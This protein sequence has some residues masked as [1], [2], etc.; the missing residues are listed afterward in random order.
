MDIQVPEAPIIEVNR[1]L[2]RLY[3]SAAARSDL[4]SG[5]HKGY[6]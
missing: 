4:V 1:S 2:A 6:D 5:P 3:Q